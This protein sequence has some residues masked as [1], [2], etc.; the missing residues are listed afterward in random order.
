MLAVSHLVLSGV[1][2]DTLQ[3]PHTELPVNLIN[4]FHSC[5]DL[6]ADISR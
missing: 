1:R 2:E 5:C 3:V 6:S 4:G